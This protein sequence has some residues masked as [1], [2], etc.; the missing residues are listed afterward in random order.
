MS[1]RDIADQLGHTRP[2]MTQDVCMGRKIVNPLTAAAL[3]AA[4]RPA[5]AE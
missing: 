3:D 2:S 5:S 4:M 1:A